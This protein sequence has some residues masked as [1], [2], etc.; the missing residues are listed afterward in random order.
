MSQRHFSS[1]RYWLAQLCAI[2]YLSSLIEAKSSLQQQ[3]S[4]GQEQSNYEQWWRYTRFGCSFYRRRNW[5]LCYEIRSIENQSVGNVRRICNTYLEGLFEGL[6]KDMSERSGVKVR[7]IYLKVYDCRPAVELGKAFGERAFCREKAYV[8]VSALCFSFESVSLR[9]C[10]PF[11]TW[12]VRLRLW[13]D[14]FQ[15]RNV[16]V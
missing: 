3:L 15:L 11:F 13:G 7:L 8:N 14:C 12:V 9:S 10:A 6:T 1:S 16:V 5:S 2:L 4:P